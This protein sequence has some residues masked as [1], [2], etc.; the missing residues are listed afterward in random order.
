M[1][2]EVI[3]VFIV[4]KRFSIQPGRL[5]ADVCQLDDELQGAHPHQGRCQQNKDEYERKNF[6]HGSLKAWWY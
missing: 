4:Q 5:K 2:Y 1:L 3:T 6:F